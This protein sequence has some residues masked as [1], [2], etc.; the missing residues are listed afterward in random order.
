LETAGWNHTDAQTKETFQNFVNTLSE[1]GV[2]VYRR[3]DDPSIEAYEKVFA[4]MPELWRSLYRFEF[5][6]PMLQ[7]KERYPDKVP[8]RLLMGLKE[9]EGLTQAEYREALNRR[10]RA[11]DLHR[12]LSL[13]ADGFITLSSPGPG[14]VGMDQGSAV[15]NEGSSVIGMPALSLPLLSTDNVPVGVQILGQFNEDERL[16]SIGRWTAEEHF[17]I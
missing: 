17:G 5:Q 2:E 14:P 6:W 11:R 10:E 12:Q 9:A 1:T 7:Y 15:F 8:P 16:T 4:E 3:S 13:R